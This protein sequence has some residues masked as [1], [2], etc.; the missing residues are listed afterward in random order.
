MSYS[1]RSTFSA[2]TSRRYAAV[3]RKMLA[4]DSSPL[5]AMTIELPP[6]SWP[7]LWLLPSLSLLLLSAADCPDFRLESYPLSSFVSPTTASAVVAIAL[8]WPVEVAPVSGACWPTVGDSATVL[9]Y[10]III[11]R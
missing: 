6:C 10:I 11:I 9:V 3:C 4:V 8:G 2:W 1:T 5:L 7:C